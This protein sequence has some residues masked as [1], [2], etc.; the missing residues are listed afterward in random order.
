MRLP[1][2]GMAVK[3]VDDDFDLLL[4]AGGPAL[5]GGLWGATNRLE[6][7]LR[8]SQGQSAKREELGR[9]QAAR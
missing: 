3:D 1:D 5:H 7:L 4:G 9:G 8:L 2:G 6:Y